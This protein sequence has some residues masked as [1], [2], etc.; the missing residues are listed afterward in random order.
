MSMTLPS[1]GP[2]SG[3]EVIA[4]T[5]RSAFSSSRSSAA[6]SATSSVSRFGYLGL[7]C[8]LGSASASAAS[9]SVSAID[10]G[11]V[12]L[13]RLGC[14]R[15]R[16]FGLGL[17]LGLALCLGLGVGCGLGHGDVFRGELGAPGRVGRLG[18]RG[19][20]LGGRLRDHLRLDDRHDRGRRRPVIGRVRTARYGLGDRLDRGRLTRRPGDRLE[21]PL[22]L[23]SVAGVNPWY[24]SR[25]AWTGARS[26][27][28]PG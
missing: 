6:G 2:S 1:T 27:V 20:D 11:F 18:R 10:V 14:G 15:E 23:R 22:E 3:L 16:G 12:V 4:A 5:R 8:R 21:R 28:D 9:A 19:D 7:G 26:A 24:P 13:E 17:G 25:R